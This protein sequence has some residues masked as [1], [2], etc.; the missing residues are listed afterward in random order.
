MGVSPGVGP[1]QPLDRDTISGVGDLD[2]LM[3]WAGGQRRDGG[4]F[5]FAAY[6]LKLLFEAIVTL[7]LHVGGHV[8]E[9]LTGS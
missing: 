8:D 1:L 7:G 4:E 6:I 5:Y 2:S 3:A 9:E